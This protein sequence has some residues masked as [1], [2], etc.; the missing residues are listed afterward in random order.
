[1]SITPDRSFTGAIVLSLAAALLESCGGG[2]GGGSQSRIVVSVSADR[3]SVA[4]GDT[5]SVTATLQNDGAHGGV[6][7]TVTCTEEPC[8]SISPAASASGVPTTYTA[9]PN[10]PA[11]DLTITIRAT[12]VSD[13]ARSGSTTISLSSIFVSVDPPSAMVDA[14]TTQAISA[15]VE[16]D[17]AHKGVTWAIAPES[18]AGT[19]S[20]PTSTSVTY[21]APAD[22]PESDVMV[23]ITAT[24]ITD[25]TIS[26]TATIT[27]PAPILVIDPVTATIDAGST[28]AFTASV[29]HDPSPVAVDVTWGVQPETGAGTLSDATSTSVTY[30]A[31]ATAPASDIE[32]TITAAAISPPGLSATAAVTVS[33]ITVSID[34][35]SALVPIGTQQAF[36]AAVQHDPGDLGASWQLLQSEQACA[37]ACGTL[38]TF[39]AGSAAYEAPGAVPATARVMLRTT[40]VTDTSKSSDAMIDISPGVLSLAPTALNFGAIKIVYGK[41]Q[42][43]TTLT[44][45]GSAVVTISRIRVEGASQFTQTNDC[46]IARAAHTSCDIVVEFK[47]GMSGNFTATLTITDSDVGSPH[48]VALTGRAVG[49]FSTAASVAESRRPRVPTPTGLQRIGTTVLKLTDDA[50]ADPLLDD[51]SAR[52]IALRLWYPVAAATACRTAPYASPAVWNYL[53]EL[54]RV[55]LPAVMTN[56]CLDAPIAEGLYPIVVFSHGLTGTFTDYTFLFEDLASRGY[57]VASVD[58]TYEATAVELADG[59]IAKSLYG[60]YLTQFAQLDDSSARKLETAR[61]GDVRFVIDE[62]Q[63]LQNQPNGRFAGHLNTDAIA[64]AGHSLGGL[65]ALEALQFDRRV[66]AAVAL[67]GMLPDATFAATDKPVLLLDAG[68]VLW[69]TSERAV[70][71]K[72]R[73]PRLA[74]NLPGAEHLTP[75]DAVWFARGAVKAGDLSPELAVAAIRDYVAAFL[76]VHLRGQSA[77]EL[78]QQRS[79]AYPMVEVTLQEQEVR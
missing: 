18:G 76:D 32:A 59:R 66:R 50:R 42:L 70:W 36:T 20:N 44:N 68:R 25:A 57:V 21:V 69:S 40:S 15:T 6:T 7:W 73:G 38:A 45:T 14:G 4:A 35:G 55:K 27:F 54:A 75:S 29:Q 19:L 60:S 1:M 58:H 37:P 53:G 49:S 5:A 52:V 13:S 30:H 71:Q 48:R 41:R 72:L 39:D 56:S 67:E 26:G 10:A 78:L 31:P 9:P 28:Q 11:S 79:I 24:S 77:S 64:V 33:A 43:T 2:G 17:V 12:S 23:T 51:G 62:L 74:I 3:T 63:R 8:G 46:S 47:S 34:P 61:L 16:N 22:P 65:T